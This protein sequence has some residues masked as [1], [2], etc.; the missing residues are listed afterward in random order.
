[1]PSQKASWIRLLAWH[2]VLAAR[3]L[4]VAITPISIRRVESEVKVN[5]C[6]SGTPDKALVFLYHW[7]RSFDQPLICF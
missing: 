5:C 3:H 7:R 4:S 2:P 1:M 6:C